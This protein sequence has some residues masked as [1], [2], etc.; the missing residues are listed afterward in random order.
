[1]IVTVRLEVT[2]Q[3]ADALVGEWLH[4]SGKVNIDTVNGTVEGRL[5]Y[6]KERD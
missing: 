3:G 2:G 5:T 6:V 4:G 1:M